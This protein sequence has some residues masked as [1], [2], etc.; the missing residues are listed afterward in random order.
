V[1]EY[2]YP[3]PQS[4]SSRSFFYPKLRST[5]P[6]M[7]KRDTELFPEAAKRRAECRC[8][9]QFWVTVGPQRV[10]I[11]FDALFLPSDIAQK[12]FDLYQDY[13]RTWAKRNR[14][15]FPRDAWLPAA[16]HD[17]VPLIVQRRHA[18]SWIK[19]MNQIS[20]YYAFNEWDVVGAR[21]LALLDAEE[22]P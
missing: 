13:V 19:L 1:R 3:N 2:S 22:K 5:S 20:R 12:L 7:R 8:P 21:S 15:S 10:T 14:K 16:F 4:D 9:D 6:W 11:E 18:W 17:Y